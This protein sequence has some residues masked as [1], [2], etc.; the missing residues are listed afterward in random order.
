M[1]IDSISINYKKDLILNSIAQILYLFCLWIMTVITPRIGS[2]TDAGIFTLALSVSNI[3]TAIATYSINFYISTDVEKNLNDKIYIYFG[4]TTTLISLIISLIICFCFGYHTQPLVFGAILL[5][6]IF[7]CTENISIV[8]T[9]SIQRSGKLYIADCALIVKALLCVSV[10]SITLFF[11]KNILLSFGII[12]IF[13]VL[14]FFFVDFRIFKKYTNF[15]LNFE[16]NEYKK[17]LRLFLLA[18]P[19][20]IYGLAFASIVSFP[21]MVLDGLFTKE[22]IGYFG[23]M[24]AISTLIQSSLSAIMIPFLPKISILYK[25]NKNKELIMLIIKFVIFVI[26]ATLAAFVCACFLDKWLMKILYPNDSEAIKYAMYFK[27]IIVST[28]VQAFVIISCLTLIA[29]RKLKELIF[30]A[31]IGISVMFLLSNLLIYSRG[32][33]GIITTYII[34]YGIM[35]IISAAFIIYNLYKRKKRLEEVSQKTKTNL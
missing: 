1:K 34:S 27:W 20:F 6:Y 23:T 7:K 32:I 5:F 11:S 25:E 15:S 2:S 3:C 16:K 26:A 29:F 30:S 4:V 13:G 21:R 31:S 28:G 18:L 10:F 22:V 14:Y 35:L 8:T 9:A 17:S 12:A 24:A 19:V 33:Y